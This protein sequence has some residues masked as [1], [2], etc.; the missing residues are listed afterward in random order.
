[1]KTET[2][3]L[4][5]IQPRLGPVA[6]EAKIRHRQQRGVFQAYAGNQYL[7]GCSGSYPEEAAK[8]LRSYYDLPNLDVEVT[9]Y[10]YEKPLTMSLVDLLVE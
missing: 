7:P 5:P 8:G 10:G 1:M 3:K 2:L 9:V 4:K 6:D